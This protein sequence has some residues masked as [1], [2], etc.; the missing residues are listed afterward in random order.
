MISGVVV[1]KVERKNQRKTLTSKEEKN[2]FYQIMRAQNVEIEVR[3]VTTSVVSTRFGTSAL[4]QLSHEEN[5]LM[6]DTFWQGYGEHVLAYCRH[7][8]LSFS[9]HF[10]YNLGTL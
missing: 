6:Y 2:I 5:G 4:F 1:E 8:A 9:K 3:T 7:S 10:W